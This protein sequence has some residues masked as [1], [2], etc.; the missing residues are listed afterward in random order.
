[1]ELT[2]SDTKSSQEFTSDGT[3][4]HPRG[5]WHF[6]MHVCKRDAWVPQQMEITWGCTIV[7]HRIFCKSLTGIQREGQCILLEN[8]LTFLCCVST[9]GGGNVENL[10][11]PIIV[12]RGWKVL[13]FKT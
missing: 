1:L 7:M 12:K 3:F 5:W 6:E 2:W 9:S 4:I 8:G 10:L 11:D 13:G